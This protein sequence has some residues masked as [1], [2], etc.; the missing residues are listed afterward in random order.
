MSQQ[1]QKST[2]LECYAKR[3][4]FQTVPKVG[5]THGTPTVSHDLANNVWSGGLKGTL[6]K[7][8]D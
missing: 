5:V 7:A 8:S 6:E 2:K 1:W 4:T 3:M